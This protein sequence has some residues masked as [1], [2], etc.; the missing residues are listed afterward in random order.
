M[1]LTDTDT[2]TDT[3][4]HTH[5]R[6]GR[7]AETDRQTDRQTD[8]GKKRQ[9][10]TERLKESQFGSKTVTFI[11]GKYSIQPSASK[12]HICIHLGFAF[13]LIK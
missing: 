8:R 4:T 11:S 9:R 12:S 7:E 3:H 5:T 2:D 10:E 1:A 13:Y 6:G